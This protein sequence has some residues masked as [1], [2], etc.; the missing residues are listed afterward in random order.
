[1]IGLSI[2]FCIGDI[3][4]GVVAESDCHAIV[5]GTNCH[6]IDQW[7]DLIEH[8]R[9]CYWSVDPNRGERI[10]W[11]L[12]NAG[13]IIQPRQVKPNLDPDALNIASGHWVTTKNEAVPHV[14]HDHCGRSE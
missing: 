12:I 4:R 10:L 13:R 14:R 1:M 9:T 8:Y 11:R 2:S 5:A 6:S 3:L 7:N